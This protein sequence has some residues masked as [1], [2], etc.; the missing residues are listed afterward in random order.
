MSIDAAFNEILAID[1]LDIPKYETD[2]RVK[3]IFGDLLEDHGERWRVKSSHQ[4]NPG[5]GEAAIEQAEAALGFEL[6]H[7]LRS[8]VR[9]ANGAELFIVH[10]LGL[11]SIFPGTFHVRYRLLGTDALV[12]TNRSLLQR[13]RSALG[14]DPDFKAF[15]QLNYIAFCDVSEGNYLAILLEGQGAGKV[16]HLDRELCA[17]PYSELDADIYETLANSLEEWLA[18]LRDTGGWAGRGMIVGGF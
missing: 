8:F 18:L 11:E 17:R 13:F 4:A 3:E 12:T 5:A 10:R 1:R 7:Q 2:D 9:I 16:F 6:P 14:N 15:R